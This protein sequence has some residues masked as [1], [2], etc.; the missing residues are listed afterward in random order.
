MRAVEFY[1]G[2]PK[3]MVPD[4]TKSGVTKDCRHHPAAQS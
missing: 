3:L 1:Q 4:N 2:V